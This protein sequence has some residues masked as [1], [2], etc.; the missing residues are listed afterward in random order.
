MSN[1]EMDVSSGS[2]S[3]NEEEEANATMEE[4]A[5]T[6]DTT[7]KQVYLP[8]Q[9]LEEGE[10]LTCDPSAYVMYHQAQTSSPCL[11]FDVIPD[12]LGKFE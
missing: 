8:G 12:S 3:E 11:S 5:T 9:P 4:T 6:A 10:E 1:N 2:S 7:S